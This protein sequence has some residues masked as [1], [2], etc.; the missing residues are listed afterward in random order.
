MKV[1]L[2]CRVSTEE[3]SLSH[4]GM[5]AQRQALEAEVAR[6]GWEVAGL[7]ED[8]GFTA[9]NLN[10]PGIGQALEQL[11]AGRADALVVAKLDR[12]S[13]SLLDFAGVMA[14][15]RREGWQLVALDLGVDTSTPSGELMASVLASFAAYERRLIG[16]RTSDALGALKAR[17][18]RLGRPVVLAPEVRRRIVRLR[19]REWSLPRIADALN[20]EGIATARGRGTWYPSTVA[21]VLKSVHLDAAAKAAKREAAA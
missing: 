13:R 20:A 9:A 8:N 6:R 5:E 4:L 3:Q 7:L 21:G 11:A 16:Q 18:A 12:L 1:L 14:R 2:Y 19:A 17:G 10:R 15:S